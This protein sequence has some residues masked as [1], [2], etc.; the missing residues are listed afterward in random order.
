VNNLHEVQLSGRAAVQAIW[1]QTDEYARPVSFLF[2]VILV[3]LFVGLIQQITSKVVGLSV[4]SAPVIPT[5]E[6]AIAGRFS[7]AGKVIITGA[8]A[9]TGAHFSFRPRAKRCATLSG[10]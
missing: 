6:N 2:L 4:W 7:E 8:A 5:A 3:A 9:S 1:R 10:S